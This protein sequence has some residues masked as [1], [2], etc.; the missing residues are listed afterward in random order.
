MSVLLGQHSGQIQKGY[1]WNPIDADVS[2]LLVHNSTHRMALYLNSKGVAICSSPVFI[3]GANGKGQS[4]DAIRDPDEEGEPRDER[5]LYMSGP[6][7][8]LRGKP[9]CTSPGRRLAEKPRPDLRLW[10]SGRC[11]A[12]VQQFQTGTRD[13]GN[14]M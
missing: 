5:D 9:A 10:S 11:R 8:S 12:V 3:S 2:V 1:E 13:T 4:I 6:S 14:A 7:I